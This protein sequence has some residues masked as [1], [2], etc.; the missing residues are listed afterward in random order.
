MT[1]SREIF[2]LEEGMVVYIREA[3]IW[4]DGPG[5]PMVITNRA[6]LV[7]NATWK[8]D[9]FSGEVVSFMGQVP[10]VISGDVD[11]GDYLFPEENHCIAIKKEDITFDQYKGVIGTAWNTIEIIGDI[12]G[13]FTKVLCAIGVK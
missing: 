9:G 13:E 7:G 3:M 1:I 6:C 5:T 10:V 4:R 2:G 8:D 12:D 11:D